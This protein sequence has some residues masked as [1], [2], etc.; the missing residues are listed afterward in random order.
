MFESGCKDT[1]F[2]SLDDGSVLTLDRLR[3]REVTLG[4]PPQEGKAA[5]VR[6]KIRHYHTTAI[7]WNNLLG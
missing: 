1:L 7:Y 6:T 5:I 2:A 3:R 4:N